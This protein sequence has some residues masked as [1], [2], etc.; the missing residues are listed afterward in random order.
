VGAVFGG[1]LIAGW[2]VFSSNLDFYLCS[3]EQ[4]QIIEYLK[5][6]RVNAAV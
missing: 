1:D 3:I 6:T 4:A 2:A 5:G